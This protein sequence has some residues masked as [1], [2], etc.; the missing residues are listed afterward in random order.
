[1]TDTE[2]DGAIDNSFDDAER[3]PRQILEDELATYPR[4]IK[5]GDIVLDMVERRPLY[6]RRKTSD[7][8]AEYF[9]T[10]DFDLTTY[11]AHPWLPIGPDDAVFECVFIPTK[12]SKITV[13]PKGQS[14]DYPRGRLIRIPIEYLYDSNTHRY[15]DLQIALVAALLAEANTYDDDK[16]AAWV[17][18]V[19]RDAF[20]S[21]VVNAAKELADVET[22]E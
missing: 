15:E 17:K 19:G 14:Y 5:P 6:I 4:E 9:A 3:D 7:S 13:E 8:A 21:D 1:M 12:P 22:S 18:G 16:G 11:K 10:H 20:G 2:P